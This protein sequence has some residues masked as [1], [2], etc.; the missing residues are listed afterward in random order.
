MK[1]LGIFTFIDEVLEELDEMK[2]DLDISSREI[3]E[4]FE[5]IIDGSSD[6]YLNINSRVKSKHSLKEK[7]LRYDY[8]NKYHNCSCLFEDLSDLIG[9]RLECRFI[10]DEVAIYKFIKKY[11]NKLSKENAGFYYNSENPNILLELESKQPKDQKNGVKIYRIDGKYQY[12]SKIINF[13]LQ[14]KSLVNIFWS[15]I[16]HK[17]IYKNYNYIIADKFYKDIMS[18]IKNSLSTI[19]Q[20][21]LLI[22]NHFDRSDLIGYDSRRLQLEQL[23]SK[24][25]YDLFALRMKKSIGILVDF[26]KS[27]DTIV[28]YV[29]REM[30]NKAE[31]ENNKTIL[32]VFERIN[33]IELKEEIDFN[34]PLTFERELVFQDCFGRIIGEFMKDVI[35]S[36]FQWNL[37]FR[38]LFKM[39]P[40]NNAGDFENFIIFYKDKMM[41]AIHRERLSHI[42]TEEQVDLVIEDFMLR[43]AGSFAKINSVEVLYEHMIKK[44]TKVF[45]TSLDTLQE[46]ITT[47]EEWEEQK[48]MYLQLF[49]FRI[50]SLFNIEVDSEEVFDLLEQI[51]RSKSHIEIDRRMLKYIN[52]L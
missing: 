26:R 10:E 20:Q 40:E 45:N 31:E 19:D 28:K 36:E 44:I 17:V 15:E 29:F 33:H 51:R 38:I 6:G 46:N 11:F 35:N 23:L 39:E 1:E 47:Y 13:E 41:E 27:C 25:I 49:E 9:L 14:I 18:A 2:I 32:G 16:E 3:E 43:F 50:L 5:K 4:Y 34:S 22:S 48:E 24:I 7:I 12:G 8:Y 42:L 37:F 52:A 30:F 21:L